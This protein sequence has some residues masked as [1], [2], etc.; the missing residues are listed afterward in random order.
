[1]GK[2][3]L[4]SDTIQGISRLVMLTYCSFPGL[5]VLLFAYYAVHNQTQATASLTDLICVS[6]FP[7]GAGMESE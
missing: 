7:V 3:T 5:W 2:S 1:M 6:S 4:S